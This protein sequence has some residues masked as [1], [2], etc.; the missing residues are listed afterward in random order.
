MSFVAEIEA[1]PLTCVFQWSRAI[2]QDLGILDI[3][4]LADLDVEHL[5]ENEAFRSRRFE[6]RMEQ[7]VRIRIDG[8]VQPVLIVIKLDHRLVDRNV[9]WVLGVRG[10]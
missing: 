5:S 4:F 6:L 1:V 8:S 10:L 2:D 7:F 3:V 9:I